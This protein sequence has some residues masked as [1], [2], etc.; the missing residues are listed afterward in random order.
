MQAMLEASC[1]RSVSIGMSTI[2][3]IKKGKEKIRA[4]VVGQESAKSWLASNAALDGQ[5][6]MIVE[7]IQ[8]TVTNQEEDIPCQA[9]G[10]TAQEIVQMTDSLI[11]WLSQQSDVD[12]TYTLNLNSIRRMARC[13][14]TVDICDTM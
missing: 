12:P 2:S 3:G 4:F 5:K 7:E 9:T 10:P 8:K 14:C 11:S 1:L 6:E 13:N